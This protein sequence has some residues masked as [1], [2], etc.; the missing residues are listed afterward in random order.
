MQSPSHCVTCTLNAGKEVQQGEEKEGGHLETKPTFFFGKRTN[1]SPEHQWLVQMYTPS[2]PLK[3]MVANRRRSVTSHLGT[4]QSVTFQGAFPVKTSGGD[5][6]SLK[7]VFGTRAHCFGHKKRG[8]GLLDGP[9][10]NSVMGGHPC[11]H[12]HG[13]FYQI[14]SRK[15]CQSTRIKPE[16]RHLFGS[17]S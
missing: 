6:A 13:I 11:K 10:Y 9:I 5:P 15:G 17:S 2:S 8:V 16:A 12:F 3:A 1:S 7:A 14:V 4:D